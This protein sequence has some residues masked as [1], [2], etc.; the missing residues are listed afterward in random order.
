SEQASPRPY[1]PYDHAARDELE[2]LQALETIFDPSSQAVLE[3][4]GLA[5]GWR[6]LDVGAGAGS[7]SRWLAEQVGPGG[8]VVAADIEPSLLRRLAGPNVV[9]T[10]HDLAAG[11]FPESGFDLVHA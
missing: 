4:L 6:C 11:P 1:A 7:V 2:R 9:V 3:S 8:T 5:A 10:E